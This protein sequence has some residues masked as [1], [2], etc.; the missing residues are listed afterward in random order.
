MEH[1]R[2]PRVF[3]RKGALSRPRRQHE[4]LHYCPTALLSAAGNQFRFGL[5]KVFGII[6]VPGGN[7][8]LS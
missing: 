1:R 7:R 5:G 4:L 3:S 8:A 2:W 6:T